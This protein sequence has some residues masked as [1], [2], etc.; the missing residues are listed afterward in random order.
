MHLIE[1]KFHNNLTKY[2]YFVLTGV[3]WTYTVLKQNQ[4]SKEQ[5][6]DL[7]ENRMGQ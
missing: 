5:S 2:L 6:N 1:V 7:Y 3:F 4:N